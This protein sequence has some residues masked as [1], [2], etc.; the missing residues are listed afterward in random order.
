MSDQPGMRVKPSD[1]LMLCNSQSDLI[2][3]LHFRKF[4]SRDNNDCVCQILRTCLGNLSC[5]LGQ[6]EPAM[7]RLAVYKDKSMRI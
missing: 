1:A 4:S 2:G 6:S 7:V 3:A 5:C